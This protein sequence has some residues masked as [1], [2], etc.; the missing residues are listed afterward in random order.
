MIAKAQMSRPIE[1][2][3]VPIKLTTHV[4]LANDKT[5]KLKSK[6]NKIKGINCLI[7]SINHT[8]SNDAHVS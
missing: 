8:Q 3:S 5:V 2:N 7:L 4:A 6:I 1:W